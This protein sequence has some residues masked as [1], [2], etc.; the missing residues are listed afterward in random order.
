MR[1]KTNVVPKASANP[2]SQ[3]CWCSASMSCSM[4]LSSWDCFVACHLRWA[5]RNFHLLTSVRSDL[6]SHF[7]RN[8]WNWLS[9]R[10]PVIKEVLFDE[11]LCLQTNSV[12]INKQIAKN[13][14]EFIDTKFD[15]FS[16]F[17]SLI[18]PISTKFHNFHLLERNL[19]F[20]GIALV[21]VSPLRRFYLWVSWTFL[22]FFMRIIHLGK[23]LHHLPT[24]FIEGMTNLSIFDLSK[25]FMFNFN[26]NYVSMYL[27][28]KSCNRRFWFI[29]LF[30]VITVFIGPS[31]SHLYENKKVWFPQL[32][33]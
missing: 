26:C 10:R 20:P 12:W 14:D 22:Y 5:K 18:W 15:I 32:L 1:T 4:G 9:W 11:R 25:K 8:C 21:T 27:R 17:H 6:P 24:N 19:W 23:F 30:F 7:H 28:P 3:L 31:N 13:I 29:L 2:R 33:N 16:F